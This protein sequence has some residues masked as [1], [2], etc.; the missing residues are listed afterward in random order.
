MSDDITLSQDDITLS[1]DEKISAWMAIPD[2]ET[3][4][5]KYT[6]CPITGQ[7]GVWV[8]TLN[9]DGTWSGQ[10]TSSPPPINSITAEDY[11]ALRREYERCQ[12]AFAGKPDPNSMIVGQA[13]TSGILCATVQITD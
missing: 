9:P 12:L 11:G 8:E 1:Q 6:T 3:D 7:E 5:K 13:S 10:N 2:K 4:S